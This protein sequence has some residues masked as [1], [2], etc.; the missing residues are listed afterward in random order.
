M[1]R[2]FEM[3]ATLESPTGFVES[4]AYIPSLGRAAIKGCVRAIS[5]GGGERRLRPGDYVTPNERIV[6]A[7]GMCVVVEFPQEKGTLVRVY[8]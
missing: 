6:T 2:S 7:D 1:S 8:M 3:K 4:I 5:E